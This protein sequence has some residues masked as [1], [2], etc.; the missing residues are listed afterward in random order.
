M[1]A[2]SDL[3]PFSIQRL[4]VWASA[5][6]GFICMNAVEHSLEIYVGP[7]QAHASWGWNPSPSPA[8]PQP[9]PSWEYTIKSSMIITITTSW[10]TNLMEL[11][12]CPTFRN[13]VEKSIAVGLGIKDEHV[14]IVKMQLASRE[15]LHVE[16]DVG[17]ATEA[18][19]NQ[20]RIS[21]V[22]YMEVFKKELQA[23]YASG[24]SV[25]VNDVKAASS[26]SGGEE[27]TVAVKEEDLSKSVPVTSTT[28][29]IASSTVRDSTT[30]STSATTPPTSTRA[31]TPIPVSSAASAS[32]NEATNS[33]STTVKK[34]TTLSAVIAS[35]D[36]SDAG[37]ASV[38]FPS[39][40]LA[41]LVLTVVY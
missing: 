17:V 13:H 32:A 18:E 24:G 31:T 30:T 28:T 41:T 3:M 38:A 7:A 20:I 6:L 36:S 23:R 1:K 2:E 9:R 39:M 5:L 11:S 22:E 26:K 10:N 14:Y 25:V 33:P 35:Q 29:A 15:D 4:P 16:Y 21:M 40:S 34:T 19:Q 27:T 8:P 37:F 12:V